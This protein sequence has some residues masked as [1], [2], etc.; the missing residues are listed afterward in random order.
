MIECPKCKSNKIKTL[1][2]IDE[3]SVVVKVMECKEC[4][5]HF[6]GIFRLDEIQDDY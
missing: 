2:I 3:N 5:N 1:E 4:L 6:D